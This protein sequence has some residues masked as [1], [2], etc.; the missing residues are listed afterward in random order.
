MACSALSVKLVGL[1]LEIHRKLGLEG[2]KV[3]SLFPFLIV[4]EPTDEW[5]VV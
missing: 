4:I 5:A 1:P 3:K 2:L